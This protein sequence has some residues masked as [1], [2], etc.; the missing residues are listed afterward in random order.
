MSL[1][2]TG[3]LMG[4]GTKLQ[5]VRRLQA[6]GGDRISGDLDTLVPEISASL[7]SWG[8][9]SVSWMLS[10]GSSPPLIMNLPLDVSGALI[11]G[12]LARRPST[13]PR[14]ESAVHG[15]SAGRGGALG[16]SSLMF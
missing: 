14:V 11:P 4:M 16:V 8:Q 9:P 2:G 6:R 13:P 12:E 7:L 15:E 5:G 3:A 1:P 10:L